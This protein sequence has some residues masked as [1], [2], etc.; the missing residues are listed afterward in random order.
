MG[1]FV[2]SDKALDMAF[3]LWKAGHS[4]REV[5]AALSAEFDANVSRSAVLGRIHR[6]GVKDGGSVA[7]KREARTQEGL[8][9]EERSS[10]PCIVPA[11]AQ[12][13]GKPARSERRDIVVAIKSPPPEPY[14]PEAI[15]I[16]PSARVTIMDLRPGACKWPVARVDDEWLFC[17]DSSTPGKAYCQHHAA[18]ACA[19]KTRRIV[20]EETRLKKR[21]AALRAGV[22]HF[23]MRGRA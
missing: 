5:A 3:R 20:S 9:Q 10:G 14:E 13:V 17:G 22:H 7:R 12:G 4:A 6:A 16:P 1:A 18:V 8:A 2:W 21:L 11:P 19:G 15:A 23:K